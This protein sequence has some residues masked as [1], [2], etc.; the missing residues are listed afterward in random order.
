MKKLTHRIRLGVAGLGRAFAVT[1][2]ALRDPR[3]EVVAGADP[4]AEARERFTQ[5][6]GARAHPNVEDLCADPAV[7]VVYVATPHQF[8]AAHTR[9]A[10]ARGKHVLVE[11][12]M[13]LTLEACR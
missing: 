1:A 11:K 6:Y 9:L 12:P 10:C 5:D 13:A 3:V 8:H 4:R 2:P 7:E